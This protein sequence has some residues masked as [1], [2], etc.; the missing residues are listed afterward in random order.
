LEIDQIPEAHVIST[1]FQ[2]RLA[3]GME[4]LG[5]LPPK[6][7][8]RDSLRTF[9]PK[10]A[11][12]VTWQLVELV[13]TG[14]GWRELHLQSGEASGIEKDLN[15]EASNLRASWEQFRLTSDEAES[16]IRLGERLFKVVSQLVRTRKQYD[17]NILR[18]PGLIE[19]PKL[20][21][22]PALAINLGRPTSSTRRLSAPAS[23]IEATRRFSRLTGRPDCFS[24]SVMSCWRRLSVFGGFLGG[25]SVML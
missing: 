25:S 23:I 1:I 15:L 11:Q 9:K 17:I 18:R 20:N 21:R 2:W 6:R 12:I 13:A 14:L 7:Q 22:D 16:L 4:L 5:D 10:L 3:D 19:Q 8:D 24:N